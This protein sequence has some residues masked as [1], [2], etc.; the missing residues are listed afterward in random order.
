MTTES[1]SLFCILLFVNGVDLTRHLFFKRV[2]FWSVL[3]KVVL[4]PKRN[5]R[6]PRKKV[7][8]N[9]CEKASLEKYLYFLYRMNFGF[10]FL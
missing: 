9:S 10:C 7:F 3:P 1:F 4:N 8:F 5:L 2:C 6:E